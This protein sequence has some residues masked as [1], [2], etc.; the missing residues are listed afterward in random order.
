MYT[1]FNNVS[2]CWIQHS[3]FLLNDG[4]R[5]DAMSGILAIWSEIRYGILL[6]KGG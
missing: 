3:V 2:D 4:E 6:S 1:E 5:E